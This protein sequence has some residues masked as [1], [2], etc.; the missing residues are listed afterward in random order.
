MKK[1]L[2]FL[3]L[4]AALAVSAACG[5]RDSGN[6][7]SHVI[8]TPIGKIIDNPQA[9]SDEIVTVKGIVSKS[10]GLFNK[11]SFTLSDSTGDILVYCPSSMAPRDG[12][13]LRVSGTVHLLYRFRGSSFCYIKQTHQR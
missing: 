4:L 8:A 7:R 2:Y 1:F 10:S 12:E 13:T 5:H 9:Y 11:S 6:S 3:T